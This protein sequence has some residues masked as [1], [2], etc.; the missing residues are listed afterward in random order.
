MLVNLYMLEHLNISVIMSQG[1]INLFKGPAFTTRLALPPDYDN[2]ADFMCD[3]FYKDEASIRSMGN[4]PAIATPLWRH[5]MHEQ[6]EAG[7]SIIAENREHCVIGAALNTVVYPSDP[8]K[9]AKYAEQ[10]D[11]PAI[12]EV[13]HFYSYVSGQP[14]VYERFCVPRMFELTSIAVSR[15][16]R[17][18]GIARRLVVES[19]H[20]ARDCDYA[21]FHTACTSSAMIHLCSSYGMQE[22]WNIPFDQYVRNGELVFKN[23]QEPENIC[24]VFI[25]FLRECR[26]YCKTSK[27]C[28]K[29]LPPPMD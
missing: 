24:R 16:H 5:I 26:T 29:L 18:L 15:D 2:V 13:L 6:V 11:S 27:K 25:D 20:L 23:I 28:T 12:K 19:W 9:L 4:T 8:L 1:D 7:L 22:V 21:V 17:G 14:N 10:S 3:A